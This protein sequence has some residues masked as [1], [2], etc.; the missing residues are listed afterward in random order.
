M[1]QGNKEENGL[2]EGQKELLRIIQERD[3]FIQKYDQKLRPFINKALEPG[4]PEHKQLA[5]INREYLSEYA[6]L[7]VKYREPERCLD[8]LD[9]LKEFVGEKIVFL[10]GVKRVRK[11]A[12]R[13][14]DYPVDLP[15]WIKDDYKKARKAAPHLLKNPPDP[16]QL[17]LSEPATG[18]ELLE[19]FN[20]LETC[21]DAAKV[22]KQTGLGT[23][24]VKMPCRFKKADDSHKEAMATVTNGG[25][26]LRTDEQVYQWLSN[27]G[28][29]QYDDNALPDFETWERYLRGARK[30]RINQQTTALKSVPNITP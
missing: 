29:S 25:T 9:K 24:T 28:C 5:A 7:A 8:T 15:D 16:I 22:I 3:C 27:N 23:K 14:D 12:G 6:K 4:S 19:G 21:I 17:T 10:E 2:T 1:T 11:M 18:H 30:Y 20:Y 26:E 13:A